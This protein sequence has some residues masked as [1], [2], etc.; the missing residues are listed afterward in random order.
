MPEILEGNQYV[1]LTLVLRKCS[2]QNR[3]RNTYVQMKLRT[4]KPQCE[5]SL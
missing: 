3:G 4:N 2:P 1:F 5:S